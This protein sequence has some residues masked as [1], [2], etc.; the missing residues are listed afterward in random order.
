V[1]FFSEI[2]CIENYIGV[3]ISI[4]AYKKKGRSCKML[5]VFFIAVLKYKKM[6]K[7]GGKQ[8]P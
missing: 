6:E 4:L 5:S 8:E 1:F 2:C 7:E 3:A